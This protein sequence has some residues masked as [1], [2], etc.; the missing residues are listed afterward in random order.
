MTTVRGPILNLPWTNHNIHDHSTTAVNQQ[1]LLKG[2]L[3]IL[4]GC[5]LWSVFNVLQVN[6]PFM[7]FYPSK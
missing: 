4:V 3:M 2:S 7:I 6:L 5:I 1:D